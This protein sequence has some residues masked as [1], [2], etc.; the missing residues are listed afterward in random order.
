MKRCAKE[1]RRDSNDLSK[2]SAAG[3]QGN[4]EEEGSQQESLNAKCQ[5]EISKMYAEPAVI[6]E[7]V[8]AL[9]NVKLMHTGG[10]YSMLCDLCHFDKTLLRLSWI[11]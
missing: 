9:Y 6:C 3:N 7:Q 10:S 1:R 5:E 2:T 11:G 4:Q 8:L